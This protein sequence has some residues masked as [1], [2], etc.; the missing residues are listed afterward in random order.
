LQHVPEVADVELGGVVSPDDS[1]ELGRV[2]VVPP[3]EQVVRLPTGLPRRVFPCQ[4]VKWSNQLE[5]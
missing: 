3:V 1:L 5:T 2:V 4:D